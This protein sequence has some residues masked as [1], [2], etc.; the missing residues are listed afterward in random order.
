MMY[1][2]FL[3]PCTRFLNEFL[4]PVQDIE[5]CIDIMTYAL[6]ENESDDF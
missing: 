4:S 2:G 5:R 6:N 3:L 1:T